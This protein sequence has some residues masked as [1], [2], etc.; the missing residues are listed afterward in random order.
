MPFTRYFYFK[1][2][3]PADHDW[4]LKAKERNGQPARE[5]GGYNAYGDLGWNDELLVGDTL[6]ETQSMVDALVRDAEVRAVEGKDGKS[7]EVQEG[8]L[9]GRE[10]VERPLGR[11]TEADKKKDVRRLDRK[12]GR[13]LYLVVKG[14]DEKWRFPAGKLEGRENLHNVCGLCLLLGDSLLII[15]RL[16]S[17]SSS[18]LQAST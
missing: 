9:V 17:E 2:D 5:L 8:D 3:T 18:K 12:L 13:T 15:Y 1:K 10:T 14:G 11:I 4:K 7:M 6:S 16:L